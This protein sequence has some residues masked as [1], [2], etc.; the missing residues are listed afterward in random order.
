[1][2]DISANTILWANDLASAKDVHPGDT[3]LILP[4]SGIQHKVKSG[5]TLASL[6]KTYDGDVNDIAS[7]N[8]LDASAGLEVGSTVIIPG[9]EIKAAPAKSSSSSSG[10]RTAPGPSRSLPAISGYFGNPLPGGIITQGIHG[11]NG[12][13]IGAPAGTP[14]YAAASGTVISAKVGGYNGGYGNVVI[15][16]HANGTQT[17][18]AHFSSVA[19][20]AGAHVNEGDMIGRVGT[21]GRSTGNHLHFEVRG[22]K[23]PFGGCAIGRTCSP[24]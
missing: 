5:E 16:S 15:I 10:G 13:D 8:G 6:A 22:A 20:S 18:Y 23:N 14:V 21:T 4:V 3:L 24:Q 11:N 1:M 17:L 12:V 9:G 7:F 2:F 19:V